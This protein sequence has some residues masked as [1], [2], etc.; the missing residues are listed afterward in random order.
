[1]PAIT[2][3]SSLARMH[4][5]FLRLLFLRL[6]APKA[7]RETTVH[8]ALHRHRHANAT[9]LRFISLS[10]RGILQW[11]EEQSRSGWW[12]CSSTPASATSRRRRLTKRAHMNL[13]KCQIY[14]PGVSLER[15]HELVRQKINQDPSLA[16]LNI[17]EHV[18][19]QTFR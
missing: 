11:P 9:T 8:G 13:S 6:Q 14:I 3:T 1:M 17:W 19:S 4:G 16:S 15:A 18:R 2:S 12:G 10:P 5:E 7:H